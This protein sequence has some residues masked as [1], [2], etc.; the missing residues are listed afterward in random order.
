MTSKSISV[1]LTVP[2]DPLLRHFDEPVLTT[3][4]NQHEIYQM[5]LKLQVFYHTHIYLPFVGLVSQTECLLHLLDII[6]I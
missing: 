1:V 6:E 5:A 3:K 4:E 2:A